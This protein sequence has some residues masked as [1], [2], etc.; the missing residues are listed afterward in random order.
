MTTELTDTTDITG[1]P[2]GCT[3]FPI[4][5]C[6]EKSMNIPGLWQPC[7]SRHFKVYLCIRAFALR[8]FYL[9]LLIRNFCLRSMSLVIQ[10]VSALCK[11]KRCSTRGDQNVLQLGYNIINI[12]HALIFRHILL[13]QRNH[14]LWTSMVEL[15]E[16]TVADSLR[17]NQW[18]VRW[19][20]NFLI[21]LVERYYQS[22]IRCEQ[23]NCRP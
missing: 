23:R 1:F 20:Q 4:F 8:Q 9:C 19:L 12:T 22:T 14:H 18:L 11:V 5:P 6:S 13:Q 17:S 10:I 2:W 15:N 3:E 7:L 16:F 21:I